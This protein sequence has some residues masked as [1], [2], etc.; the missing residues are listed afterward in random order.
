MAIKGIDDIERERKAREK[1]KVKK[2]VIDDVDDILK[3]FIDR[4]KLRTNEEKKKKKANKTFIRKLGDFL[5][6]IAILL[7]IV[8][9]F[10][11][12]I[13]ALRYFIK[14]LFGL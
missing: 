10:L 14:S 1:D 9:F 13:W 5:L 7:L 6:V 2:E 11:F 4:L 3:E 8:N 12:N